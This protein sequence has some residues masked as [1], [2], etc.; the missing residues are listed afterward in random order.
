MGHR[1]VNCQSLRKQLQELVNWRYIK[2]FNLKPGQP[3]EVKVQK[4]APETPKQGNPA[5][6]TLVSYREVDA[7]FSACSLKSTTSREKIIYINEANRSNYLTVLSPPPFLSRPISFS[8]ADACTV[9]FSHYDALIVTMHIGSC[10]VSRILV[11]SG[12]SIILYGRAVDKIEDT[13]EIA[14]AI[15]PQT[16]SNLYGFDKNETHSPDT[17]ALLV[18]V[19]LY[20][21]ITKFYVIGMASPHN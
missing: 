17:I 4:A 19:D 14:R 15:C 5:S 10:Q 3:L 9:H 8:E 18:R 20:N 21:V 11:D 7:I 12:S 16:Q 2:G 13:S 1:T 6:R